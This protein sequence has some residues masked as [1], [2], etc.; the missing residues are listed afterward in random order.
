MKKEVENLLKEKDGYLKLSNFCTLH[1]WQSNALGENVDCLKADFSITSAFD[2]CEQIT[3][4]DW[5]GIVEQVR[6]AHARAFAQAS[7]ILSN[8]LKSGRIRG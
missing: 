5:Q 2:Y 3:A 7:N 4:R 8:E 1:R 6:E